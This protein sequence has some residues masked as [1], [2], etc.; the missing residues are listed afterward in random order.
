MR[1]K[2]K[3]ADMRMGKN[4]KERERKKERGLQRVWSLL[5]LNEARVVGVDLTPRYRS[6]SPLTHGSS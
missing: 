6:A 1:V 3:P 2:G 4:I 5:A